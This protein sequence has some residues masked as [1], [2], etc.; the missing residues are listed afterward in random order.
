MSAPDDGQ[1]ASSSKLDSDK[2]RP[3]CLYDFLGLS[4]K[5]ITQFFSTPQQRSETLRPSTSLDTTGSTYAS[6][7]IESGVVRSTGKETDPLMFKSGIKT[8]DELQSLRRRKRGGK[9]LEQYHRSQN[10][11]TIFA[12]KSASSLIGFPQLITSLLKPMEDHTEEAREMEEQA[13]LPV[14]AL[15]PSE[16]E[17][18]LIM[19]S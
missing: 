14:C 4:I 16:T 10:E 3:C 6:V 7:D 8:E 5:L 17:L 11:V 13:R 9:R 18:I 15:E 19:S 2:V 12:L 1:P